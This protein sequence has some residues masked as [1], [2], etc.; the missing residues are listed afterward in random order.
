MIGA[1]LTMSRQTTD[2]RAPVP[3]K[4]CPAC[5][6]ASPV[7]ALACRACGHRWFEEGPGQRRRDPARTLLLSLAVALLGLLVSFCALY[8]IVSGFR[9]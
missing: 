4:S 6:A 3:E 9:R 2:P 8:L 7:Y 1:I 5:G